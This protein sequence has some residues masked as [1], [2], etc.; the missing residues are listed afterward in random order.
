MGEMEVRG[1][2]GTYQRKLMRLVDGIALAM[3]EQVQRRLFTREQKAAKLREQGGNCAACGSPVMSHQLADGD[4]V[5]AWSE[6]GATT[7]ENLQ[8]LHRH[9]HQV[10]TGAAAAGGR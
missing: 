6:G 2:N 7:A 10:K 3:A 9:C 5:I 1:R 4:H 8:I